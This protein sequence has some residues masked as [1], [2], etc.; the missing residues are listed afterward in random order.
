[1]VT[2]AYVSL[3]SPG[4]IVIPMRRKYPNL[5]VRPFHWIAHFID[6]LKSGYRPEIMVVDRQIQG[7]RGEHDLIDGALDLYRPII[8]HSGPVV[9]GLHMYSRASGGNYFVGNKSFDRDFPS[10]DNFAQNI[11]WEE[12]R[13]E[14]L[15]EIIKEMLSSRKIHAPR[16]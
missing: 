9:S 15:D 6:A 11:V 2:L 10:D 4:D 12:F 14:V 8:I 3:D 5:E 7:D 1:M 13:S 16:Q